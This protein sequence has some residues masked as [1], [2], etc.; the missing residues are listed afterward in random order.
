MADGILKGQRLRLNLV[1]WGKFGEALAY[2]GDTKVMV[3][4]GIPGEEVEAEVVRPRRDY[5]AA[6]VVQVLEPSP[7]R[8]APPCPY[9]GS[10]TGCQW[11]HIDY[12]HQ[13][14]L[15]REM[16]A[17]ALAQV[18]G[19]DDIQVEPTLASPHRYSYRNHARFTVQKD[20][21][22]GFVHRESRKFVPID[23]C[24]LMDPLINRTLVQ[25]QGR[26]GE[27]TQLSIRGGDGTGDYLIQPTLKS[28]EISTT[29][30][31]KYYRENLGGRD[32]RIAA[33][34][35]FQVNSPQAEAM[36]SLAK[37][38]LNLPSDGLLVDAYAGVGTFAVL[39]APYVSKVVAIEDSPSAVWDAEFNAQ[40][41]DN[42]TFIQGRTEEILGQME[43]HPTA[44][45]LDPPRVGCR[46]EALEA[47]GKLH[48]RHV[49]YVS[50]EPESLARDLKHLCQVGFQI[51][52]VQPIDMFPQTHHVECVVTLSAVPVNSISSVPD[53]TFNSLV[54]ASASP[55][56][57][58][59]LS[60][61]GVEHEVVHPAVDEAVRVGEHPRT[62]VERLALDKARQVSGTTADK[63]VVGADSVV[64][65]DGRAVGKPAD[66][67][68]AT[69]VLKQ[70]RGRQHSVITGVAVVDSGSGRHWVS[71]CTTKVM[72][73]S[74]SDH[75]I[76]T[77]VATGQPMDKAGSYGIQDRSFDPA[78][79]VDGCYTNV[80]GLPLCEV[81]ELLRKAGIPNPP[82]A[83]LPITRHCTNCSLSTQVGT[84]GPVSPP[85]QGGIAI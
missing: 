4:G 32:F 41:I 72:M 47:V 40:G 46:P 78:S 51:E 48:P 84:P 34:S 39:L 26:C 20:G 31:Q 11:Q 49:V 74:Y 50:C 45:I 25:L 24:L 17:H 77:Y 85:V 67:A 14:T 68:E 15:K 76:A 2:H 10:C 3:F 80:V 42:I 66:V 27:T 16:V 73:R 30:G 59:L 69:D 35:F 58:E 56:R 18:G 64:V 23:E 53:L 52:K 36:I 33:A 57:T 6:Q 28:P 19:F 44:L 7:Y 81:M 62:M 38:G 79:S 75:E 82:P 63:L 71:S 55:R 8:V 70:L 29:S 83:D 65:V 43:D 13:L 9:F 21:S 12:Q 60:S 54:L 61:L 22:L 37:E 5:L 1:G